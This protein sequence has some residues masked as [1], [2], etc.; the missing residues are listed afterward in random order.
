MGNINCPCVSHGEQL[1]VKKITDAEILEHFQPYEFP[2][3]P[4]IKS[5]SHVKLNDS[6]NYIISREYDTM[7]GKISGDLY[8]YDYFFK[9]LFSRF[10]D[11][12]I[13][14][15]NTKSRIDIISK[16][17]TF[18]ISIRM[19]NLDSDIQTCQRLGKMHGSM[20]KHPYLFGIY[21]TTIHSC[22]KHCLGNLATYDVMETWLHVL[23]FVLR[24]MFP[25]YLKSIDFSGH[26]DGAVNLSKNID[27]NKKDTLTMS[28]SPQKVGSPISEKIPINLPNS[29]TS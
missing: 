23:A 6:W 10:I 27:S 18:I 21:A 12:K 9:L 19:D 2:M 15:P 17:M 29:I 8:F 22:I 1:Y 7:N 3:I 14:F 5:D 24:N 13:I 11:F 26:Y 4:I 25:S 28:K 16:A 20:V